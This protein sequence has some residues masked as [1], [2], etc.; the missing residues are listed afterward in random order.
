MKIKIIGGKST[1]GRISILS[2]EF[3][4]TARSD[5]DGNITCRVKR[6]SPLSRFLYRNKNLPIPKLVRMILFLVDSMTKKGWMLFGLYVLIIT[7]MERFLPAGSLVLMLMG[8]YSSGSIDVVSASL[9]EFFAIFVPL[10]VLMIIYTKRCIASW[11]GA[12]HMAI[13]AYDL[14]IQPRYGTLRGNAP[15]TINVED[16]LPCRC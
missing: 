5:A 14:A 9:L 11:H 6:H 16:D 1:A 13:A 12:E 15:S 3:V 10:V 7:L 4:S 8:K 2:D